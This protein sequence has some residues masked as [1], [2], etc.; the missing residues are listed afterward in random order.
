VTQ[1]HRD[2]R[3]SLAPQEVVSTRQSRHRVITSGT[4]FAVGR[5][6]R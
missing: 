5:Q 4:L 3:L 6:E 1:T 2:V